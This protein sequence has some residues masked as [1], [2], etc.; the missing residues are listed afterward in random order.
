MPELNGYETTRIIR[1]EVENNGRH[2]PIIAMTAYAVMGDQQNYL[3][4]GMDCYISKPIRP[5]L[6]RTKIETILSKP[7]PDAPEQK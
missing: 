6:L 7:L 5:D 1:R 3:E 2:L 4:T